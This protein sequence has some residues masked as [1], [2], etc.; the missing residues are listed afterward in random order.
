MIEMTESGE[1][2]EEADIEYLI[3]YGYEA[4]EAAQEEETP[5]REEIRLKVDDFFM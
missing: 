2:P 1:V 4:L 3:R 5:V